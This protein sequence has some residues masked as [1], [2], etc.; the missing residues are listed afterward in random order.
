MRNLFFAF[1]VLA[2]LWLV[3]SGVYKPLLLALGLGS[4]LFT[5]WVARRMDLF[6]DGHGPHLVLWRWPAYLGWLLW[7]IVQSNLHVARL[8]FQPG[9]IAPCVLK[10]PVP[11]AGDFARA[12]YANS[13]TLTPGTVS[14]ML[15]RDVLTVHALDRRAADELQD[16]ELGRRVCALEDRRR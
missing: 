15:D 3:L 8:V 1:V 6:G 16:G 10:V 11:Q 13:V 7:Q 12:T 5:L 2:A 9:R 14:L 4:V